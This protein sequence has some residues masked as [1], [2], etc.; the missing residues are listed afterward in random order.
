L[1]P[2]FVSLLAS[3]RAIDLAYHVRL[4][5]LMLRE[6]AVIRVDTLTFSAAGSPWVNQQWG[7]QV[8]LAPLYDAGGWATLGVVQAILIGVSFWLVFRAAMARGTSIAVASVASVTGFLVAAPNLSLRPQLLALPLVC[9]CVWALALRRTHPGRLW[10]VP[11]AALILANLHGS[12]VLIPMLVGLAWAEDLMDRTPGRRH[13]LVVGGLSVVATLVNPYGAGVWSYAWNL[14]TDDAIRNT[15]A[16]WAPVSLS[17]P[18]GWLMVGSAV[19]V[20]WILARRSEAIPWGSLLTLTVFFLMAMASQRATLW[21]AVVA[22]VTVAPLVVVPSG[23]PR[24]RGASGGSTLPAN[25]VVAT[26]VAVVLI[27]LPWWRADAYVSRM[28]D[29]PRGITDALAGL[30]NGTRVFAHQAWA[31]WFE[32]ASPNVLVFVDSRIELFGED[33]WDDYEEV[34]LAGV[35]WKRALDRW[36]PDAIVAEA[37]WDIVPTLR[38]DPSWRVA[39]EDADGVVFIRA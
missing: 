16:E 35:R 36:A 32:Y 24:T 8:V 13:L 38:A 17:S 30:P 14:S 3:L 12:F 20:G 29:A 28:R 26:L 34:A 27:A 6:R 7:A 11:A 15:V 31:S 18:S 22:P 9:L 5:D 23:A 37:G 33:V 2:A 39:Y 4:G 10:V 25:A 19:V 21:W 1:V